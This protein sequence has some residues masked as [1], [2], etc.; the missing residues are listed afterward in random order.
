MR[1]TVFL[2]FFLAAAAQGFEGRL[3]LPGGAPAAGF[4]ISVTGFPVSATVGPEGRFRIIPS[5]PLPFRLV[6]ISPSG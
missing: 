3:T 6:A 5:P 2:F 4:Q 1:W